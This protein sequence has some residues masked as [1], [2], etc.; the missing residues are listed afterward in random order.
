M[1]NAGILSVYYHQQFPSRDQNQQ[2]I[3]PTIPHT[4]YCLLLQCLCLS[5]EELRSFTE[6]IKNEKATLLC[7]GTYSFIAHLTVFPIHRLCLGTPPR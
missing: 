2:W 5:A 3:H 4:K 7:L 1:A 6:T